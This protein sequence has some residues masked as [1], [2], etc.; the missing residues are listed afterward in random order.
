MSGTSTIRDAHT[1]G[2]NMDATHFD[3]LARSLFAGQTRRTMLGLGAGGLLGALG[4]E[5]GDAKKHKNK[6]KCKKCGPCEKCQKGKCKPKKAGTSC[7]TGKQ[8]FAKGKCVACDV[9]AS[10]CP[11]ET[12]EAALA[13][14]SDGATIQL[15]PGTYPS[16]AF[17]ADKELTVIGAGSGASGTVLDGGGAASVLTVLGTTVTLRALRLSGGDAASGGGIYNDAGG[18]LTLSACVVS[19]NVGISGGG[20]YNGA[21]LILNDSAVSNN[22]ATANGGG[23]YNS[24]EGTVTLTDSTV[25]ENE[26]DAN[27]GGIQNSDDG[28]LTLFGS[29]ISE[30]TASNGGGIYNGSGTA[31]LDAPSRV[32]G[33]KASNTGGGG[34]IYNSNGGT[35]TLANAKNVTG[36]ELDNCAG[37]DVPLCEE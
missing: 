12:L 10:G 33:N 35:V 25:N 28:T 20:I 15:C 7:G 11:H 19:E 8:C 22:V 29:D 32:T 16:N 26:A 30:N 24:G 9:C 18:T 14:A 5:N 6:K 27:G 36:N 17:I 34:G 13:A 3:R 23:I 1:G 2:K 31:T 37:A 21:T 4:L